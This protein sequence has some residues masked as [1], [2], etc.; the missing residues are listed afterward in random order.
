MHDVRTAKREGVSSVNKRG[1][2]FVN[3][4]VNNLPY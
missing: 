2:Q 3:N 4:F 1:Q